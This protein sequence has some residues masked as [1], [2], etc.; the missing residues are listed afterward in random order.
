MKR[1]YRCR[2]LKSLDEFY[3]HPKAAD[4]YLNICKECKKSDSSQNRKANIERIRKYDR[5]RGNRQDSE[6]YARW[7]IRN[8]EKYEAHNTLN[9]A[10]RDGKIEKKPCEICGSLEVHAHHD[11]YNLPLV[12]KWLCPVHHAQVHAEK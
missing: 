11:N 7:R 1:C 6:Y 12:V 5:D 9:N 10:I 8:P 2:L 4:G 3:K